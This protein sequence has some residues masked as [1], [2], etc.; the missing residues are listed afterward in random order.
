MIIYVLLLIVIAHNGNRLANCFRKRQINLN[1]FQ[2][3]RPHVTFDLLKLASFVF[4]MKQIAI[5]WNL[6]CQS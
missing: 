6:S 1:L 5:L 4:A 3:S 2:L